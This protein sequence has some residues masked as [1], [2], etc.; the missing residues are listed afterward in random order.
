LAGETYA[1]HS[2]TEVGKAL[3]LTEPVVAIIS[4]EDLLPPN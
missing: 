1:K 2:V 4:P 3:E